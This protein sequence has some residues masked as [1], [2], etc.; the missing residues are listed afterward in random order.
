MNSE[1]E[2]IIKQKQN[3]LFIATMAFYEMGIIRSRT[4]FPKNFR[5]FFLNYI[6]NMKLRISQFDNDFNFLLRLGI[7]SF[8]F[9]FVHQ[10]L[11]AHLQISF[12]LFFNWDLFNHQDNLHT[13]FLKIID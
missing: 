13:Q 9:L 4:S 11:H 7:I 8:T 12:H 3:I 5:I 6:R 10:L 1:R 2:N